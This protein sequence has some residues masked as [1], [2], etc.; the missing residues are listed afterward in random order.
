MLRLLQEDPDL[1]KSQH[2]FSFWIFKFRPQKAAAPGVC[3]TQYWDSISMHE[4]WLHSA[5]ADPSISRSIEAKA[6][7]PREAIRR[8]GITLGRPCID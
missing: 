4:L 1:N 5:G 2:G 6:T 7:A 8:L 3:E